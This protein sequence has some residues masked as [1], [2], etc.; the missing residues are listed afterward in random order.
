MELTWA[1]KAVDKAFKNVAKRNRTV[2]KEKTEQRLKKLKE[3][4]NGGQR[5]RILQLVLEN[6]P[7]CRR[8]LHV[9]NPIL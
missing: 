5:K 2:N 4:D 9:G 1:K 6:G 3:D 8:I 7:Y